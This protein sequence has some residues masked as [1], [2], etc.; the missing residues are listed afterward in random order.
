MSRP[1][2]C[3][4][5]RDL[6]LADQPMLLEVSNEAAGLFVLDPRLTRGSGQP[7][8]DYLFRA[9]AALDEALGGRL[10]VAE[11]DPVRVVPHVARELGAGVVR[12]AEDFAPYGRARD[13]AVASALEAQ[14][15]ELRP[16]GSP[17]AVSPGRVRGGSGN[18]YR[19]FTPFRRAWSAHGWPRPAQTGADSTRWLAAEVSCQVALPPPQSVT[20]AGEQ[21]AAA[22][23]T[24][25][26]D[27]GLAGY[28]QHR[29]FPAED[30]TSRLSAHLKFGALHPRTLL[31]DLAAADADDTDKDVFVTELAWR[32]FYADALFHR[33][34]TAWRNVDRRFDRFAWSDSEEHF[35]AWQRGET[36]YPIVDAGMRQ[37]AAEGWMHNR[38]RM[39]TASFLT[40][41][42][43]LP[44]QW[45]A[46]HFMRLLVDGD[47]ASN[48]HGWQWT[49]G[50]G[51]DAAPYFR[52]FNPI[53]QGKKFDPDGEYVRR[54]VP[55][56]RDMPGHKVHE[57]NPR[58]A[59][60]PPPIVDHA[61]E[62]AEALLRYEAVKGG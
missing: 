6:R 38:V 57:P 46:R 48:S 24:A 22:R 16:S 37:L 60:Y 56:L 41:D 36:G 27:G 62:R 54:W 39:I 5:R 45:G 47:L 61:Q 13:A 11:G 18:P 8:L 3:W 31:R 20:E 10:V 32:E 14:G 30:A 2:L 23:W 17:Y 21:A 15:R 33:P 58:P 1:D 12:C 19:V 26:L 40:K 25:F 29:D 4:F 49:A 42:L 28:A 52:V 43:H 9:L 35:A 59:G 51:T 53:A 34:H 44:W 7:R 55:E 50:T